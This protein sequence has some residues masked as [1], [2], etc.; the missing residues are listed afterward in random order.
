MLEALAVEWTR[1]DAPDAEIHRMAVALLR[2]HVDPA[3][4]I[5]KAKIATAADAG[6]MRPAVNLSLLLRGFHPQ[7]PVTLLAVRRDSS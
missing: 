6:I 2:P 4:Q 7:Y 1:R 5:A 3:S